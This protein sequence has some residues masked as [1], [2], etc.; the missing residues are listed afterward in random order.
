MAQKI[1]AGMVVLLG[2]GCAAEERQDRAPEPGRAA[3]AAPA[4]AP[5][6]S[7]PVVLFIGTSL[8]AGYGL[9]EDLAYPAL[10]QAKLDSA[11]V[12]L[13]VLNGGVSGET[14]AGGLARIDWL[15]RQPVAVLVL[16]LGANDGLRGLDL[17]A[18]RNNLQ[19]IIDRTRA[20]YPDARVVVAGMEAP[21]N[22]GQRYTS[23]FRA[24]FVEL[25]EHNGATLI[26]FLLDRV[27]AIP[28]LNQSDGIH[29]TAEGHEI[30]AA[31]VWQALEEVLPVASPLADRTR[32]ALAVFRPPARDPRRG[33]AERPPSSG[34]PPS[35]ANRPV[36]HSNQTPAPGV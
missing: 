25:A 18:M 19:E 20:A 10:I 2:F 14:S 34:A 21:P 24:T 31:T 5:D 28:A 22:L 4:A 26:P 17:E 32:A 7:E 13:R 6:P 12:P 36:P 3:Q 29:P 8:T 35:G 15:L 30:L 11:G 33:D 1:L 27:A 23:A 9:T 16:E